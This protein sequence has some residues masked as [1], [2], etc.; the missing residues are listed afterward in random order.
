MPG[1][2]SIVMDNTSRKRGRPLFRFHSSNPLTRP[3]F[4][5]ELQRALAAVGGD[6]DRYSGHS[7]R[8]RAATLAAVRGI[9]DSQIKLL[10]RWKS[11]AYQRY[12]QPQGTQLARVARCL[13]APSQPANQHT[14]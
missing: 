9:E 10:G 14:Q 12:I 1:S 5:E 8:S 13:S 11:V 3:K 7:F 2:G 4:V 6:S